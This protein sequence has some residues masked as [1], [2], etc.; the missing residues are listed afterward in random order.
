VVPT[1]CA[2]I[3]PTIAPNSP[4]SLHGTVT[5]DSNPKLMLRA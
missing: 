1:A 3:Q 2:W 4:I 5:I